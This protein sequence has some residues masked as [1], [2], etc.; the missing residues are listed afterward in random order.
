MKKGRKGRGQD[1]VW[2]RE[3]NSDTQKQID[4]GLIEK[5][6]VVVEGAMKGYTLH[7]ATLVNLM[8][9]RIRAKKLTKKA[10]VGDLQER[11]AKKMGKRQELRY[12]AAIRQIEGLAAGKAETKSPSDSAD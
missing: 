1:G 3:P 2:T 9:E 11:L 7:P 4:A 6:Q 12:Q 8:A 5:R 10:A